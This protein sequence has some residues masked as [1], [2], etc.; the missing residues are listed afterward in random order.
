MAGQERD[1]KKMNKKVIESCVDAFFPPGGPINISGSEA[2]L[3][4]YYE[5]TVQSSPK[6]QRILL[7][8]LIVFIQY[9]PL[10]I[11]PTRK[12]FS[13]LTQVQREAT[14]TKMSV[15]N[16]YF[17]RTC[18]LSLRMLLCIGYIDNKNVASI[19]FDR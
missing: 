12:R 5:N 2:G 3:V 1:V 18:F 19:I 4:Q 9:I 7:K 13:S 6:T 11:G 14:L 15:S 16:I 8:L 17:V 10:I